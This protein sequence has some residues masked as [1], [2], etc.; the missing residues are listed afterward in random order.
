MRSLIDMPGI[1]VGGHNINNLRYADDT[2]LIATSQKELQ[3]MIDI[4][5]LESER[6]GLSLNN[7]K[8]EVM[9][10][11][12][13]QIIPKCVIKVNGVILRQVQKFKYLGTWI[14]SD[15]RCITEIKNRIG[16]AKTAFYKIKNILCN[17]SLSLRV[18]KRILA[19]YIHPVLTYGCESWTIGRQAKQFLE[20]SEM[21]FYRRMLRIPWTA[22][23][24]NQE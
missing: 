23:K 8:T 1:V 10:V 13:K 20:A 11:S 19:C 14:T 17:I 16:Q 22:K 5:V 6:M 18:K 3:E 9:V 7:G 12:K 21:W 24:S 2:V 4:V 15:G